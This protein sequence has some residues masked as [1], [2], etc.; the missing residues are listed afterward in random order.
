MQQN[1]I[2]VY[3]I[4]DTKWHLHFMKIVHTQQLENT[5]IRCSISLPELVANMQQR[6]ARYKLVVIEYPHPSGKMKGGHAIRQ[7]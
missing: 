5:V 1:E 6:S 4:I 2:F 7:N 3:R